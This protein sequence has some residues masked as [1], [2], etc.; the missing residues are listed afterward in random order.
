MKRLLRVSVFLALGMGS[1][2]IL[3]G[4]QPIN[5]QKADPEASLR[6]IL[7]T[8]QNAWN[9]GNVEAF[10]L[11][12]WRSESLTF[13]GSQGITHGFAGVQERYLTSYPDP[14]ARAN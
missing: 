5:G 14:Q 1:G 3:G 9:E 10:L 8:Q 4:R 2:T 6:A 11:G 12:Y 13:S 7:T